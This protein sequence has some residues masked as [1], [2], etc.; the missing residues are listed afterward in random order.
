MSVRYMWRPGSRVAIDAEIA[1]R[2]LARIEREVGEITPASVLE[3]ARSSNNALHDHFEWDDGRAAE[4]HRLSQAG[5]LIRSITIDTSASNLEPPKPVRAFVSIQQAGDRS[6][7]A[8]ARAM[9]DSELRKQVLERAWA[10]LEAL[11]RKYHDLKELAL[12][13][14]A[15]DKTKV[16]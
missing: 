13:F 6:Y 7:I 4:Q 15:M 1:G 8:T 16:H 9:S 14:Q 11:R 5:E 12:I 10:E 3:R 2:E